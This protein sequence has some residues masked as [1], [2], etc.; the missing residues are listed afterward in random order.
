MVILFDWPTSVFDPEMMSEVLEVMVDRARSGMTMVVVVTHQRGFA[1]KVGSRALFMDVFR[2][3]YG[4]KV[5]S[6][7]S[8]SFEIVQH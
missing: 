3:L 6:S 4:P 7:E 2:G 5:R 1:Q 8:L